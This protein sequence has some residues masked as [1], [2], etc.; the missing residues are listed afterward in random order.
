MVPERF[1]GASITMAPSFVGV[2]SPAPGT[3]RSIQHQDGHVH[4][5]HA[6]YHRCQRGFPAQSHPGHREELFFCVLLRQTRT[7]TL[8]TRPSERDFPIIQGLLYIDSSG[9]HNFHLVHSSIEVLSF[10]PENP[11]PRHHAAVLT[12]E[13]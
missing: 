1:G 8:A 12:Q 7:E 10:A 4:S 6:A 13:D 3:L 2:G 9:S 5:F 11:S